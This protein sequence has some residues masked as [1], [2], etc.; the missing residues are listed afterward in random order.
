MG[1]YFLKHA[2]R[3]EPLLQL[4]REFLGRSIV[5]SDY[6]FF[7]LLTLI[8]F[9]LRPEGKQIMIPIILESIWKLENIDS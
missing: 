7:S 3:S 9:H 6:S 8:L 5:L 1:I 2:S 4:Q